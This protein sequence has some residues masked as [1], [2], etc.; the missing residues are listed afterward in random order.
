MYSP[1]LCIRVVTEVYGVRCRIVV[2]EGSNT[3]LSPDPEENQIQEDRSIKYAV[4]EVARPSL[5]L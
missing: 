3:G 5:T 1:S 4:A 2:K